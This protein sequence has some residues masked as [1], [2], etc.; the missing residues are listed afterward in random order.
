M[1]ESA[2]ITTDDG[3]AIPIA[4][5]VEGD[6]EEI[7][8]KNIRAIAD[9]IARIWGAKVTLVIFD[10]EGISGLSTGAIA[11]IFKEMQPQSSLFLIAASHPETWLLDM[12]ESCQ[13]FVWI[14]PAEKSGREPEAITRRLE[15]RFANSLDAIELEPMGGLPSI[16]SILR[17]NAADIRELWPGEDSNLFFAKQRM[18]RIVQETTAFNDAANKACRNHGEKLQASAQYLAP[19]E[20]D[21]SPIA[22]EIRRLY[23]IADTLA[24]IY[25]RKVQIAFIGIYGLGV[26]TAAWFAASIFAKKQLEE[27]VANWIVPPTAVYWII[28]AVAYAIYFTARRNRIAERF[29]DYRALA[30]ALR[31]QYFWVAC[32]VENSVYRE[33][34][35]HQNSELDWI[36]LAIASSMLRL[37]SGVAASLPA[38][39]A[40]RNKMLAFW[41]HDQGAYLSRALERAKKFTTRA[42]NVVI[43]SFLLGVS[44]TVSVMVFHNLEQLIGSAGKSLVGVAMIICPSISA[45]LMGYTNKMGFRFQTSLYE[46]ME[47]IYRRATGIFET[48]PLARQGELAHELGHQTLVALGEWLMQTRKQTIDEPANPFRRPW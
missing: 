36:R 34:L 28:L 22:G 44:A 35:R 32:G 18:E 29:A 38:P 31:I 26:L 39:E 27:L 14:C 42:R 3:Q 11:S 33:Y 47:S 16:M 24:G 5:A 19:P 43:V 6:L 20:A 10:R 46:R 48:L 12:A 30:E 21:I 25:R 4:V 7:S 9:N 13:G 8:E 45:A 23:S 1:K 40:Q 15:G 17:G 41:L 2:S 37:K